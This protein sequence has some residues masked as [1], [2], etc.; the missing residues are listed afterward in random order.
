M[1]KKELLI[2]NTGLRPYISDIGAMKMGPTTYPSKYILTVIEPTIALSL[3][4]SLL[5]S[6]MAGERIE[7]EKGVSSVMADKS[8]THTHL[9]QAG[10]LNGISGSS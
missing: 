9:C 10:K 8:P 5:R 7:D 6:S 4:N 2:V 1:Q 3:P